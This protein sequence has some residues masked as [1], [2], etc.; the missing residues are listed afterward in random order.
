MHIG[1]SQWPRILR[2]EPSSLGRTLRSW[3]RIMDIC[4][5][6]FCVCVVLCVGCDLTRGWSPVQGVVPN[7]YRIINLKKRPKPKGL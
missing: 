2:R 3:V 5:R 1:R 7:V 6:L 4:V